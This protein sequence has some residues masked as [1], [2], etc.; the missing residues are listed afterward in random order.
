MTTAEERVSEY[1]ELLVRRNAGEPEF[2]QAVAEVLA[3]LKIVLDKD[4]H[5][6]DYGL[7]QRLCE[8]ERQFKI[9]RAH[10]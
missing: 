8:P 7:I 3:S 4:P 1:Y 5:Y 10:V 2:H 9:G 6:A